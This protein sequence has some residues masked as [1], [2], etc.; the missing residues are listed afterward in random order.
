MRP[1]RACLDRVL[2]PLVPPSPDPPVPVPPGVGDFSILNVSRYETSSYGYWVKFDVRSRVAIA[3]MELSVRVHYEGGF[4][5]DESA[6]FRRLDP[7]EQQEGTVI[8]DYDDTAWTHVDIFPPDDYQCEGCRRY[9]FAELPEA[10]SADPA[11]D[12]AVMRQKQ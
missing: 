4:F 5:S 10:T 12:A 7:G 1:I 8:P 3:Q 9:S 6:T 2:T 11:R